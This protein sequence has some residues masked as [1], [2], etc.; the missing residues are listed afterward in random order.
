MSKKPLRS[1]EVYEI[2]Q[3]CLNQRSSIAVID[4]GASVSL[5]SESLANSLR[6]PINTT[7]TAKIMTAYWDHIHMKGTVH[8]EVQ[9]RDR[10]FPHEF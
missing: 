4:T 2:V 6:V 8:L 5:V 7:A 1:V 9:I 3:I 10:T